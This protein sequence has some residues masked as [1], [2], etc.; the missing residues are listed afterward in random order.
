MSESNFLRD[1]MDGVSA[2]EVG[3]EDPGEEPDPQLD[4]VVDGIAPLHVR[5]MWVLS[6]R[7]AKRSKELA[8]QIA[9]LH[10]LDRRGD[11]REPS[12]KLAIIR[13]QFEVLNTAIEMD[14]RRLFGLLDKK[15]V[16]LVSGFRVC[17]REEEQAPPR[18]LGM[19]LVPPWDPPD[20]GL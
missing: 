7:L 19:F 11:A 8:K 6:R 18:I 14:I 13:V 12:L 3:S 9:I 1:L 20:S 15:A 10:M 16:S 5:K 17:W 4:H 2:V